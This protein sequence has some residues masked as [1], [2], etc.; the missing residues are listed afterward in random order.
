MTLKTAVLF[1]QLF[2]FHIAY[3]LNI[4]FLF[5]SASRDFECSLCNTTFGRKD[6]LE[7]HMKNFHE[8]NL[9][10]SGKVAKLTA[11][12]PPFNKTS[13]VTKTKKL[14]GSKKMN[15]NT[16]NKSNTAKNAI[17]EKICKMYQSKSLKE[18]KSVSS[19]KKLDKTANPEKCTA[20]KRIVELDEPMPTVIVSPKLPESQQR[21][22]VIKSMPKL[23]PYR[24]L[25]PD[26][27]FLIPTNKNNSGKSPSDLMP[28]PVLKKNCDKPKTKRITAHKPK[29]PKDDALNRCF[30]IIRHTSSVQQPI[31]NVQSTEKLVHDINAVFNRPTD[32]ISKEK[33]SENS[34]I[35][36]PNLLSTPS[37][38]L[39]QGMCRLSSGELSFTPSPLDNCNVSSKCV[40]GPTLPTSLPEV[41]LEASDTN[42]GGD[43]FSYVPLGESSCSTYTP[44]FDSDCFRDGVNNCYEDFDMGFQYISEH[45]S[46]TEINLSTEA[47][48]VKYV[49]QETKVVKR[50]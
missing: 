11:I 19:N 27:R 30:R 48:S 21:P 36:V 40:G 46:H 31:K 43:N 34:R 28:P 39:D 33:S 15:Q 49:S 44:Y 29:V 23:L 22:S 47:K 26:N 13:L 4:F 42:P 3:K 45:F 5:F 1:I 18:S 14:S 16:L 35:S 41:Q 7:R 50:Y 9:S 12:I 8:D 37:H 6:N 20:E 32:I 10:K 25:P 17:N 24:V 2:F 38:T